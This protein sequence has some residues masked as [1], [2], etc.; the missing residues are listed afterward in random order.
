MVEEN[1]RKLFQ[2]KLKQSSTEN[3]IQIVP[4]WDS[5]RGRLGGRRGIPLLMP[6]AFKQV[7]EI[8]PR[9]L[10]KGPVFQMFF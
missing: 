7:Y 10:N 9:Q 4:R 2:R 1:P 5:N 6:S 3:P 8:W